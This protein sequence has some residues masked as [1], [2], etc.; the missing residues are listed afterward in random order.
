MAVQLAYSIYYP[1][2]F[3]V[4]DRL[5]YSKLFPIFV[6]TRFM[7]CNSGDEI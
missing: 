5:P 3:S 6:V 7:V 2:M 1:K 4:R